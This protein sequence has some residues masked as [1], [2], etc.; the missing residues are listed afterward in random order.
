[1]K[2]KFFEELI[3]N[4]HID[5][6]IVV[7][8]SSNH[9]GSFSDLK[10]LINIAVK[11]RVDVLKFQ[12][13]KPNTLSLKSKNS[14][15]TI[16][17]EKKWKNLKSRYEIYDRA[18]TPWKWI[19]KLSKILNKNKIPWFASPF[20]NSAIKFLEKIDCQAYKIA[21]PEIND[22]NLIEE[23]AKKRK[24]IVISTGM[25]TLKD[26]DN[27]VKT[28]KK[29]HNKI[30]ILK[31]TSTY[32]TLNFNELNLNLIKFLKKRYRCPIGY[33]DHTIGELAPIIAT[34]LGA[35]LIEK[36]FKL[37]DDKKS[38]DSHFSMKISE[39][40]NLKN[41]LLRVNN[42]IGNSKMFP[43]KISK[44]ILNERRSLYVVSDIKKGE[45]FTENN[46]KSIRPGK[47]L[48]PKYLKKFYGKLSKRGIKL[49]T[50]LSLNLLN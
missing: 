33:S 26:L 12:V 45:K 31:C 1:M 19:E 29:Y 23:I 9:K 8:V 21:S 28:I 13:Y 5:T 49:G 30:I 16:K 14:D 37:D 15:F 50:R 3:K 32:P 38:I 35:S 40:K 10:K 2:K 27:A 11:L 46:I 43:L 44:K 48:D 34:T 47:G 18:H 20:D 4:K 7:E 24:P 39:Y 17:S 41:N 22:L 36:H 42:A 6:K 25:A